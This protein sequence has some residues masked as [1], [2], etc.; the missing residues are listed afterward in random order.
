MLSDSIRFDQIQSDSIRLLQ[1]IWIMMMKRTT[2]S[3][4]NMK[5]RLSE[6]N[7]LRQTN[8]QITFLLLFLF[9]QFVLRCFARLRSSAKTQL[10][11]SANH[12]DRLVRVV[13]WALLRRMTSSWRE[14][15]GT[16]NI[17]H[18][19]TNTHTETESRT[20]KYKQMNPYMYSGLWALDWWTHDLIPSALSSLCL[21]ILD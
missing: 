12:L 17:T 11:A 19:N 21:H 10:G 9:R 1:W 16:S 7:E 2:T 14:V 15:N 8:K 5:F 18:T 20:E 4:M 3:K 6:W 13:W